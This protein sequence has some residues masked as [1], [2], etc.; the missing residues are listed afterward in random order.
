MHSLYLLFT[1]FGC[2]D[3]TNGG[4][5][6]SA[7]NCPNGPTCGESFSGMPLSCFPGDPCANAER[8]ICGYSGP[9]DGVE[10]MEHK[11]SYHPSPNAIS[12]CP[13]F[14]GFLSLDLKAIITTTGVPSP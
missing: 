8:A 13:T 5:Y 9:C 10:T 12:E 4:T 2:G 14:E 7:L 3:E 1:L 6:Y 11:G